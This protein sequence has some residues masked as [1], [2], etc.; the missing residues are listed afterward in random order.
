MKKNLSEEKIAGVLFVLVM[1]VFAFAHE[2]SKKRDV[3][4]KISLTPVSMIRF[5]SA[6]LAENKENQV[7]ITRMLPT[8][9]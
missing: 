9:K 5:K 2:D 7:P 3:H 1:I 8:Q 6:S 4:Y